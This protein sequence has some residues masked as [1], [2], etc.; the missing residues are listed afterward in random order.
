VALLPRYARVL[1]ASAIA[2]RARGFVEAAR[3]A[4]SSHW[5]VLRGHV[6]PHC[7]GPFF[8]IGTMGAGW[9]III[10]SSLSFL[11]FAGN[12]D[13]PDWAYLLAQGRGYVTVAWWTVT[14]PGLAIALFAVATNLLGDA[15]KRRLDP[16]TGAR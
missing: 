1:R 2:V 13:R 15:L 11:G 6:L 9:A 3:V 10:G 4:G 14:F 5:A 8:V 12:D 16:P 7:L